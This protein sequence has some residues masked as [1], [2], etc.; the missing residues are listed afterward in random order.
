MD[1]KIVRLLSGISAIAALLCG[2]AY[3][4]LLSPPQDM[5]FSD[6][7]LV[8]LLIAIALRSFGEKR[9]IDEREIRISAKANKWGILALLAYTVVVSF[10]AKSTPGFID[11][12]LAV[13]GAFL[14]TIVVSAIAFQILQRMPN[15]EIDKWETK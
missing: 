10:T 4:F 14:S 13:G 7:G 2:S 9:K 5:L 3:L 6:A 12:R 15:A 11:V 8:F 1:K